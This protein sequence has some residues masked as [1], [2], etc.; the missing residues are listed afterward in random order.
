MLVSMWPVDG[1]EVAEVPLLWQV[2]QTTAWLATVVWLPVAG[3]LA[4]IGVVWQAV[5]F[6]AATPHT[7][8]FAVPVL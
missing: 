7:G 8:V 4:V 2:V 6:G 3:P 1:I 5:Q